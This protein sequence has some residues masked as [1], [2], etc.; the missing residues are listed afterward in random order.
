MLQCLQREIR[1]DRPR[2]IANQQGQVGHLARL[3]ALYDDSHFRALALANE[4]VM[5]AGGRQQAGDSRVM[6]TH[7]PV[8]ED[9]DRTAGFDSLRRAAAQS[10]HRPVHRARP[11]VGRKEER[12]RRRLDAGPVDRL[13][14]LEVSLREDRAGQ[15]ELTSV[16]GRLLEQIA[17]SAEVDADRRHELLANRVQRRVAHLGE[18][19]LE[20]GEQELRAIGEYGQGGV[21]AHGAG[22]LR[23]VDR[24]RLQ[25]DAEVLLCIPERLLQVDQR[26]LVELMA[27]VAAGLGVPKRVQVHQV[28][29]QPLAVGLPRRQLRLDRGV[30]DDAAA[31]R[32]HQEHP[33]GVN[34]LLEQ[35][36][37]GRDVE[38]AHLRGHDQRVVG[39]DEV[40][41]G[42]QP[43]AV[44]HRANAVSVG[45]GDEG[46]AIPRLDE[47]GV[48]VVEVAFVL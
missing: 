6:R 31:L 18:Q 28:V 36:L 5:H 20:V 10:V 3:S 40:T 8:G 21:V 44:E 45:E 33:S 14:L 41:E 39:R 22:W 25:Q 2:A 19:L 37:L 29:P 26:L 42:T 17:L 11:F 9:E 24:H 47:A 13:D 15:P 30:V 35:H 1:A 32:V 34:A 27:P 7:A 48:V 46:R 4:V 16:K 43:V 12:Q 23:A 38:N